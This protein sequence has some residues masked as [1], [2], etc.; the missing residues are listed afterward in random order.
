MRGVRAFEDQKER[1]HPG[2]HQELIV[3][4]QRLLKLTKLGDATG[5]LRDTR[6]LM[7][8]LGLTLLHRKT[9][10]EIVPIAKPV[11]ALIL[12]PAKVLELEHGYTRIAPAPQEKKTGP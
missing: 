5:T 2:H 11:H 6:L 12:I 8:S 1:F 4:P 9:T 7:E 3:R 10:F